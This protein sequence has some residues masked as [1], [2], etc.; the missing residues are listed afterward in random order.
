MTL[1][2]KNIQT[3]FTYKLND[4]VAE[5]L[6]REEPYNFQIVSKNYVPK[7][8]PKQETTTYQKVV[9]EE[10]P[11]QKTETALEALKD[12]TK[13]QL[14]D[15]LTEKGISFSSSANKTVLI[16]LLSN[17]TLDKNRGE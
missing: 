9:V 4:N 5:K 13:K 11:E 3:G 7:E 17:D 16:N 10:K 6:V 2:V 14:Q 15:L 1:E 8:E 12:L